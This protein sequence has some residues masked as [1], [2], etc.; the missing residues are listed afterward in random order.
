MPGTQSSEKVAWPRP[1]ER[2]PPIRSYLSPMVFSAACVALLWA[3]FVA[4]L[5][6]GFS[7]RKYL[8]VAAV[9]CGLVAFS[10]ISSR[11]VFRRA[12]AVK[13][14]DG[15]VVAPYALGSFL[16]S[17]GLV[18][19]L[20]LVFALWA[21]DAAPR[22]GAG[23]YTPTV[24]LGLVAL[25]VLSW[26]VQVALGNVRPGKVEIST[27]GIRHRDWSRERSVSWSDVRIVSP[28]GELEPEI[29]IVGER[30]SVRSERFAKLWGDRDNLPD[31]AI[32]IPGRLLACDPAA[33][34][35]LM[36]FYLNNPDA[37]TELRD[38][39]AAADRAASGN[40]P[41]ASAE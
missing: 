36:D 18:L 31:D 4:E 32:N 20:A 17:A 28:R 29:T 26:F 40:L 41:N 24:I 2:R 16:A 23:N 9:M 3:T 35:W 1:W 34:Y 15:G 27:F 5:D 19:S 6:M 22:E 30:G 37:R 13:P 11:L 8:L 21:I 25:L 38:G 14:D 33:V 10:G 12:K 7:G 39:R